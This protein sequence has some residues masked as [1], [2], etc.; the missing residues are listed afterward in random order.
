MTRRSLFHQMN[1]VCLII[2]VLLSSCCETIHEYPDTDGST[3]VTMEVEFSLPPYLMY[4]EVTFDERLRPL[5]RVLP[6]TACQ[7][8]TVADTLRPCVVMELRRGG[9]AVVAR[10]RLFSEE[11]WT[12]HR[13][14]LTERLAPGSYTLLCWGD[15]VPL[16][17]D[18]ADTSADAWLYDASNLSHIET[19]TSHHP[20]D[21]HAM[22]A[23][24][25]RVRFLVPER[26]TG[27]EPLLVDSVAQTSDVVHANLSRTQGRLRL[28]ANDAAAFHA[29]TRGI[30]SALTVR[31]TYTMFVP[32][33]YNVAEQEP[34]EYI[35]SYSF[36]AD[37]TLNATEPTAELLTEYVFARH[38]RQTYVQMSLDILDADGHRLNTIPDL[39]LPLL[40]GHETI[41]RG[42][43]LTGDFQHKSD[44]GGLNVDENFQG[45]FT[46]V[47]K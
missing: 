13:A 39:Q 26:V 30:V 25:A 15:Y 14:R 9:G 11:L 47:V 46:I 12:Q 18:P 41:V 28:V 36:T 34:T 27:R 23:Q 45:E 3:D 2:T 8:Y 43:L 31:A 42:P 7:P 44:P 20:R 38:E 22:N 5:E 33:G 40:A 16:H 6:E 21:P 29:K 37:A 10:R 24:S 35:S 4:K 19:I 32:T 1:T 17:A